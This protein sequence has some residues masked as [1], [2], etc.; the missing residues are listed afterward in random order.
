MK[1]HFS[2]IKLPEI[3]QFH[4][5]ICWHRCG[6]RYF[7]TLLVIIIHSSTIF[8]EDIW[9]NIYHNYVCAC[10]VVVRRF[11]TPWIV[12]SQAPLFMECSRQECWSGL[13]FP[14]PGDLPNP[15]IELV[16]PVS[17]AL[18]CLFTT[19]PPQI[20]SLIPYSEFV[21]CEQNNV[22]EKLSLAPLLQTAKS[23]GKTVNKTQSVCKKKYYAAM[24]KTIKIQEKLSLHH[25]ISRHDYVKKEGA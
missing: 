8:M 13:P 5:I 11:A 7:H 24:F 10:S 23:I 16:S 19:V 22:Y 9:G 1:Y 15:G 2:L 25:G 12:V 17:L 20:L 14:S 4:N 3:K 21:T 6:K 18:L